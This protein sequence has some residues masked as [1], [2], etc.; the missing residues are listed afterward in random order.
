MLRYR[1]LNL[2]GIHSHILFSAAIISIWSFLWGKDRVCR[3]RGGVS[4]KILTYRAILFSKNLTR[5]QISEPY[6]FNPI[7]IDD[8]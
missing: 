1:K 5:L 3:M 8:V 7:F 6:D 2:T 4:L